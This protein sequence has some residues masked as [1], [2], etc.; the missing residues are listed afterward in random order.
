MT[1]SSST[2]N[3]VTFLTVFLSLYWFNPF[4]LKMVRNI[5]FVKLFLPNTVTKSGLVFRNFVS[6]LLA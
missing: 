2:L 3:I 1:I 5:Q 6:N 4:D